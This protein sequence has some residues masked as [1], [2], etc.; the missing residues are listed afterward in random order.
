MA[1]LLHRIWICVAAFVAIGL[2]M[3]ASAAPNV[4]PSPRVVAAV[5]VRAQPTTQ[6]EALA[7]L[8]P[9]ETLQLVDEVPGWY[10]VI[11]SDGR[12]GYV[13]KT[14]TDLAAETAVAPQAIWKVHFVDVGTGLATFVEGPDFTL[15]YDGGSNDD[16]ATGSRNRFA[17]YI[18]RVRPDLQ[19]IDH[20]I[21]SH[22]HQD[23]VQLLPDLFDLY[24]IRNVWD[25]GRVNDI[26]GYRSF[27][28]KIQNE[29]GI[30]YHDV[31]P[32][33]GV[34]VVSEPPKAACGTHGA[35]FQVSIPEG[36][37]IVRGLVVQLGTNA[38]MMFLHADATRY[39][40]EVNRNSVPIRLDLGATRFLF[41]G[42]AE[43]GE[44]DDQHSGPP[45]ANS[46]EG[47]LLGCCLSDIRA[48][49]MVAGHHG[50][51]TSSRVPFLDAV[52]AKI[53]VISSGPKKYSGTGLPDPAI[54]QELGSRGEL[55]RTDFDD[56]HCKTDI[57]KVGPDN[58]NEPGGC[59]NILVRVPASGPV[60]VNYERIHD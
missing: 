46:I 57:A 42:D 4:T 19:I 52:G 34:N 25:S 20:L 56:V 50:S 27:L 32:A 13:S 43:A 60:L 21:L 18:R 29:H 36:Q 31:H 15:V 2:A 41:M 8:R 28:T 9:G 47:Q 33:G 53:F 35:P 10:H 49:F 58:D 37:P 55:W 38:S 3:P 24:Q 7:R 1:G 26:C 12:S 14:W 51:L 23:H 54:V 5:V 22:P 48:D 44:R 59:D 39:P 16:Y 17:A 40:N 30:V 45:R 6:S 11:L